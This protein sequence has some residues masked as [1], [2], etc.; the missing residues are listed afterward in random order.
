MQFLQQKLH[1]FV[2]WSVSRG[3]LRVLDLEELLPCLTGQAWNDLA[4]ETLR[5]TWGAHLVQHGAQGEWDFFHAQLREAVRRR[6]LSRPQDYAQPT[7]RRAQVLRRLT[8]P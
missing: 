1:R 8:S 6:N 2:G 7:S 4:F 5:R 3:G